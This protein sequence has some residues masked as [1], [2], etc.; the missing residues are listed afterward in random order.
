VFRIGVNLGDVVV[1]GDDPMGDAVN[2]A[3]RLEQLCAPGG[4]LVS[5][6]AFDHLQGRLDLPLEFTGEQQVKNIARPV[7]SYRVRLD[8]SVAAAPLVRTPSRLT[9][10]PAVGCGRA[11]A[12]A[13]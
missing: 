9:Q 8:G 13:S 10:C 1:E 11:L 4:V 5:G 6:T 12:P 3:A 2:I 7:R